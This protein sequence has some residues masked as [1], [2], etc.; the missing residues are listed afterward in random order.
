MKVFFTQNEKKKVQP[1]E[2]AEKKT[3][4]KPKTYFLNN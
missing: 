1:Q 3:Q 4:K 2:G